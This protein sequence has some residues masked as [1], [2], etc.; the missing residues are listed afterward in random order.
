MRSLSALP[1][2]CPKSVHRS[3]ETGDVAA[4]TSKACN[5]SIANRIANPDE[6]DRNLSRCRLE[7]CYCRIAESHDH[8]GRDR[9]K[10]CNKGPHLVQS[11]GPPARFDASMLPAFRTWTCTPRACAAAFISLVSG[12]AFGLL[13][14]ISKA[15][16]V[17]RGIRS[18]SSSTRF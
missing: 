4:R 12:P 15:M 3:G 17:A 5:E 10:L 14:F 7:Q 13:G 18:C 6:H 11:A 9:E 8:V 16:V 2:T 1:A